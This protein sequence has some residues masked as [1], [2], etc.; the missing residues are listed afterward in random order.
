MEEQRESCQSPALRFRPPPC[1]PFRLQQRGAQQRRSLLLPGWAECQPLPAAPA[2]P[3][4]RGWPDEGPASAFDSA[5]LRRGFEVYRQVC[6]ACHSL[7]FLSFRQ[8]VGVTHTELQAK[9]LAASVLVQDVDEETGETRLR[10][11]TLAD[12]LPAPYAGELQ[13]REL[14]HGALPPDLTHI[15]NVSHTALSRPEWACRWLPQPLPLPCALSQARPGGADFLFSLLTGYCASPP[16][17]LQA[18]PEQHYNVYFPSNLLLMPPPLAA[19]GVEY[20]DDTA[21]SV[22]QQAKDVS[23]FLSWSSNPEQ[24]ERKLAGL[25]AVGV[26]LPLALL[27][28]YHKR[29]LFAPY[30]TRKVTWQQP[31]RAAR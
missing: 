16:Y 23:C 8:L 13:A 31:R 9:A 27:V 3:H 18:A 11:G 5:S 10:P 14:N 24:D 6:S 30:K 20:E 21:A 15:V 29:L 26:A 25:K 17:G 2:P 19:G 7:R 4:W 12:R 28:G 22:S 1:P